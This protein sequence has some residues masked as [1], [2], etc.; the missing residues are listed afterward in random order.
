MKG[1]NYGEH[2]GTSKNVRHIDGL[3]IISSTYYNQTRCPWHYHQNAHFAFTTKGNLIETHKKQKNYLSAGCLMYNHSQEPHCN[4]NYSEFVSALHIDINKSW[5][6]KYEFRNAK[7]EGVHVLQNP[8]LK[9][10]II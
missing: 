9:K 4:S 6:D 2:Y 7:I 8:T 5:F 3:T 10:L 1:L